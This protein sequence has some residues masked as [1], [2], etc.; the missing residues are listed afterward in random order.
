MDESKEYKH[1]DRYYH[2][3]QYYRKNKDKL[4][5]YRTLYNYRKLY[6]DFFDNHEKVKAFQMNRK[7]YLKIKELEPNLVRF[8]LNTQ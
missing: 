2:Q 3:K 4:K 5:N 1:Q 8:F 6:G 7:Y